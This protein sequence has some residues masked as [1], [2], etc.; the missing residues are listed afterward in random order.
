MYLIERGN[1]TITVNSAEAVTSWP[2]NVKSLR[3]RGVRISGWLNIILIF[4]LSLSE[5][6]LKEP[7]R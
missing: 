2:Q 3:S 5:F 6:V 1:Y 7:D 4:N